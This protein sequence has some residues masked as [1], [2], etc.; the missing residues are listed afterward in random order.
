[1]DSAEDITYF[2]ERIEDLSEEI[3]MLAAL[4]DSD[5]DE[6][7][8][9]II[10][11][12]VEQTLLHSSSGDAVPCSGRPSFDI[13]AESIE[14]LL[15]CGLKLQQIADLYDV[16]E[17]TI[18]RRM[19]QFDIRSRS[20]RHSHRR[21]SRSRSRSHSHRKKSRS[22][23]Y[24]PDYRRKKSRSTSPM[25]NRRRHAGSRAME[26][27]NGMELDGRRIRVDY[28]ITKRPHTPTP[29]IYMGRPTHSGSSS[30]GGRRRDSYYD[31]G[32]DRYDR[33]DEYDYRYRCSVIEWGNRGCAVVNFCLAVPKEIVYFV[34]GWCS[35]Q[36]LA[37]FV[38]GVKCSELTF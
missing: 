28:S 14:H 33:Y 19:S 37:Y 13:P 7:V 30:S 32:Y 4:L 35:F 15:L 9:E 27:A 23:S 36:D 18:T 6:T 25:S 12:Q 29:G 24:T 8:F 5:I 26:R 11:E 34:M 16:S 1:M 20:R 3:R 17:K 22:R 21:Y 10:E 31:R 38:G 2:R